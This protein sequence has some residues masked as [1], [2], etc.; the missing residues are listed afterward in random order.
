MT[1]KFF[2]FTKINGLISVV[3]IFHTRLPT[4]QNQAVNP[5]VKDATL[6]WP[7]SMLQQK[8][9]PSLYNNIRRYK[10]VDLN[11]FS[12]YFLFVRFGKRS[13]QN[14]ACFLFERFSN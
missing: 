12:F 13:D 3:G 10:T 1:F 4:N 2:F 7:Y 5:L 14:F 9:K 8:G 6:K 11:Y